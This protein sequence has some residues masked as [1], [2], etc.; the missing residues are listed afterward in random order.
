MEVV[1]KRRE[2]LNHVKLFHTRTCLLGY[3]TTPGTTSVVQKTRNRKKHPFWCK[4]D[5]VGMFTLD[6]TRD[7]FTLGW[8]ADKVREVLWGNDGPISSFKNR[9][10]S[11]GK[12]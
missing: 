1:K 2:F 11:F 12:Y 8:E 3:T 4:R 10:K 7:P 9:T 5:I 6:L